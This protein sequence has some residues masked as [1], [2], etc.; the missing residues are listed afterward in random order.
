[1]PYYRLYY[2]DWENRISKAMDLDCS[3]DSEAIEKVTSVRY[4]H[5]IELW[6]GI[7][8]VERIEPSST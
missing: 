4:P 1:M 2:V 8:L 5:A 3:S 7:P 6:Q